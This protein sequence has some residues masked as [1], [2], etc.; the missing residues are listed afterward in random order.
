MTLRSSIGLLFQKGKLMQTA[1][2][3]VRLAAV[4]PFSTCT[5]K[6]C[7][8]KCMPCC[9]SLPLEM[10]RNAANII[11]LQ[12]LLEFD[13]RYTIL[14][15]YFKMASQIRFNKFSLK[16]KIKVWILSENWCVI[17]GRQEKLRLYDHKA[18]F[19]VY[20]GRWYDAIWTDGH[21][22]SNQ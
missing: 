10:K 1:F 13:S 19:L 17:F 16:N 15:S 20:L 2:I 21:T 9:W 12:P 11:F 22:C 14:K 3:K 4:V 6:L 7:L 5:G 8:T 18:S